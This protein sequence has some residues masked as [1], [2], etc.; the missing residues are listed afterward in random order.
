MK[1]FYDEV[2]DSFY[3]TLSERKYGD[4]VEAAPGVVL[5]F[6]AAGRLIGIDLEHASKTIDV[7]DL[8]LHAEPTQSEIAEVQISGT[9]IRRQR[10]ALGLSQAQL[11]RHLTVAANTIARWERGELKVEHPGMLLLALNELRQRNG[12]LSRRATQPPLTRRAHTNRLVKSKSR[13]AP[14]LVS[15]RQ[16]SRSSLERAKRK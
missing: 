16:P 4:S 3:L 7:T 6:D 10:E 14:G 2:T 5:D 15:R 11:G 9:Q 8:S 12:S 13:S 1:Y